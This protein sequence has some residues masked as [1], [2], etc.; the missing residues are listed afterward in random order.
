MLRELIPNVD[1]PRIETAF[2]EIGGA[3]AVDDD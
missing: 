1:V 3:V 2:D